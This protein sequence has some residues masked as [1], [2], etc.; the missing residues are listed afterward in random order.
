MIGQRFCAFPLVYLII[1]GLSLLNN[2]RQIFGIQEPVQL[3]KRLPA[4]T[5]HRDAYRHIFSDGGGINIDMHDLC[6]FGK[7][8][9]FP[10]DTVIEANTDKDIVEVDIRT[11]IPL[12]YEFDTNTG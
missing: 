5:D 1:P 7:C 3:F 6:L 9:C 2:A 4:V 12:V 10:C 8:I 11:G